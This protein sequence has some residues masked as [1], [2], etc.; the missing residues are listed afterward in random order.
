MAGKLTM[1]KKHTIKVD[2]RI[3]GVGW[4]NQIKPFPRKSRHE[5]EYLRG[6]FS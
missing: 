3:K 4:E 6:N 1:M 2:I 5:R